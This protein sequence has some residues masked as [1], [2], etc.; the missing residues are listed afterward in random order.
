MADYYSLITKAVAGLN[1][2]DRRTLYE[3]GRNALLDELDL[4]IHGTHEHICLSD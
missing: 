1:G 2:Q 3:R 4:P